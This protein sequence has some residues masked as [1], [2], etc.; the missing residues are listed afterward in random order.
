MATIST[1][2]LLS[3]TG[4]AHISVIKGRVFK[5]Q[6]VTCSIIMPSLTAGGENGSYIAV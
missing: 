1:L 6:E 4:M 3:M 5:P 2:D